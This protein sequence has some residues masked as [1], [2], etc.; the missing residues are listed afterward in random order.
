MALTYLE[1]LV[2]AVCRLLYKHL[3]PSVVVVTPRQTHHPHLLNERVRSDDVVAL[4]W[5]LLGHRLSP[6]RLA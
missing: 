1:Q 4:V 3:P 2:E 5:I 6:R